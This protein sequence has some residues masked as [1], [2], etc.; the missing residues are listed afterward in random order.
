M[1]KKYL[2][3]LA[4]LVCWGSASSSWAD[5]IYQGQSYPTGTKVGSLTCQ[6]DGSWR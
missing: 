3:V 6:A 5:C 1:T 4:C 2:L